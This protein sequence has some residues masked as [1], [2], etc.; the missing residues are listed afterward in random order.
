MIEKLE[1]V[2]QRMEARTG[3]DSMLAFAEFGTIAKELLAV[4]RAAH[5]TN[6]SLETN[7]LIQQA[8]NALEA[9]IKE[10]GL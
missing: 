9:K 6:Q 1:S 2:V 5:T 4:V 7:N 10:V 3:T 8:L